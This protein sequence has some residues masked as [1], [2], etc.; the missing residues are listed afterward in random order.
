MTDI[1]PQNVVMTVLVGS[2][3]FFVLKYTI[4]V[5]ANNAKTSP[6][7]PPVAPPVAPP[8][9]VPMPDDSTYGVSPSIDIES[10]GT[11]PLSL[12]MPLIDLESDE[13][14]T[15]IILSV[16]EKYRQTVREQLRGKSDTKV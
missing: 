8:I 13:I 4:A 5:I 12:T 9:V 14:S 6:T 7:K 3:S 1:S 2:I 11:V 10:T 16:P 15:L